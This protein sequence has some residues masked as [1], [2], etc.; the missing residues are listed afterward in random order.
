MEQALAHKCATVVA[1]GENYG[2]QD[3]VKILRKLVLYS[4]RRNCRDI[5]LNIKFNI[6]L[7]CNE[8]LQRKMKNI[9]EKLY[10]CSKKK[11][12]FIQELVHK[13]VFEDGIRTFAL[14]RKGAYEGNRG[15]WE[16]NGI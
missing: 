7:N 1:A 11:E 15:V 6:G 3:V 13:I 10:G 12:I 14:G 9:S 8:K 4:G 2:K 5:S 16:E